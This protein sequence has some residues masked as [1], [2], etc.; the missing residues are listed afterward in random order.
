MVQFTGS[1][2]QSDGSVPDLIREAPGTQ[3]PELGAEWADCPVPEG[4]MRFDVHVRRST[5]GPRALPRSRNRQPAE[6]LALTAAVFAPTAGAWGEGDRPDRLPGRSRAELTVVRSSSGWPGNALVPTKLGGAERGSRVLASRALSGGGGSG[7]CFRVGQDVDSRDRRG[8]SRAGRWT[9]RW[10]ERSGRRKR[11]QETA[12]SDN[13]GVA[14]PRHVVG[15][16]VWR[17]T[18]G[19]GCWTFWPT[20]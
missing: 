15:G 11:N 12:S 14:A 17:T 9:T 6:P 20:G 18:G 1:V 10:W 16:A 7:P 13:A 2:S 19:L 3:L 4:T 5:N 8:T